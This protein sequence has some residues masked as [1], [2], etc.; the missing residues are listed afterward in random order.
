MGF[1]KSG[2]KLVTGYIDC[3]SGD[4]IIHSW[5]EVD[6]KVMDYV[7]NVIL[8]REVYY[9]LVNAE[10][11]NFISKETVLEDCNSEFINT[12]LS[13]KENSN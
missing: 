9:K 4:R 2:D 3:F 8:D 6:D 12:F 5:I 13:C 10:P 11:L 1:I 7:F